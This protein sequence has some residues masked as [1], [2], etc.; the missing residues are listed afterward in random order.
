MNDRG[1]NSNNKNFGGQL[2]RLVDGALDP[3]EQRSLL[4]AL[5]TEPDGWRRCALTFIEAQTL[6]GEFRRI[7]AEGQPNQ[8]LAQSDVA[9]VAARVRRQS[10][11]QP[12]RWLV[13]AATLLLAFAL[14]IGAQS[15]WSAG[16]HPDQTNIA[17]VQPQK[18]TPATNE[19]A[20]SPVNSNSN[21]A[22]GDTASS[23]RQAVKVTVPTADGK[24]ESTV[25]VPLV[26]A[27]E[28]QM[29]SMLEKQEPVLSDVARQALA[30]TGH[31]V[32]QY[33]AFYPVQLDDGTQAV[34]PVDFV[35][36]RDTSSWQ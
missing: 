36:V 27:D 30:S 10:A 13:I 11:I 32:E 22:T 17:A 5:E 34:V 9:Q 12:W 2:D 29:K 16:V 4:A 33:R 26:A 7:V 28:Q 6:R 25:E 24:G 14:G 1:D 8:Q 31:N 18:A 19:I 20:S 3:Q 35:E 15:W 23:N 21:S